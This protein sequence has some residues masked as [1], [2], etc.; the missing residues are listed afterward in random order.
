[1]SKQAPRALPLRLLHRLLPHAE[2]EEV[3]DELEA[4]HRRRAQ[5]AG[6]SSA[7]LWIWLQV[8]GS[9]P[10]L[11]RRT[12]WRGWTGFEPAAN[13]LQPGGPMIESWIMDARYAARRLA[14]RPAYAALAILTLALGSGGTAAIFSV[15]R[16]LLIEP[17]PIADEQRVGVFWFTGSWTEQEFLGLRPEFP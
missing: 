13:R 7:R 8:L 11:L 4:E 6:V 5:R 12:W 3:V 14:R 17:L 10:A 2:A 1:L 9:L 15:V 16:T